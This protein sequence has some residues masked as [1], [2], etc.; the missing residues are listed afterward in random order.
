M[1]LKLVNLYLI[2]FAT[3]FKWQVSYLQGEMFPLILKFQDEKK[4]SK[5]NF[6]SHKP[7]QPNNDPK[8]LV[9][10]FVVNTNNTIESW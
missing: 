2:K 6:F 1:W 10:G 9:I 4:S 8:K 5:L 3:Q 7:P